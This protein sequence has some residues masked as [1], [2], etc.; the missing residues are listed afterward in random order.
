MLFFSDLFSHAQFKEVAPPQHQH[1]LWEHDIKIARDYNT[2]TQSTDDGD[3]TASQQIVKENLANMKKNDEKFKRLYG[4]QSYRNNWSSSGMHSSY[5]LYGHDATISDLE[6]ISLCMEYPTRPT[7]IRSQ[8]DTKPIRIPS[9]KNRS[10]VSTSPPS[11]SSSKMYQSRSSPSL[12]SN[13]QSMSKFRLEKIPEVPPAPL[14]TAIATETVSSSSTS[15]ENHDTINSPD[16]AKNS[17]NSQ[18]YLIT[19]SNEVK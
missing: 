1:R 16:N 7:P 13:L 19:S 11:P 2:T 9:N 18:N 6:S 17:E 3:L 10:P 4:H 8:F 12:F 14:S 5:P 15:N